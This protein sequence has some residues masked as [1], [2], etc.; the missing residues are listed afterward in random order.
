MCRLHDF[1]ICDTNEDRKII[2]VKESR[3]TGVE[4]KN[5]PSKYGLYLYKCME[6][7]NEWYYASIHK[8]ENGIAV[9]NECD[10]GETQLEDFHYNLTDLFWYKVA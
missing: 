8:D 7:D 1:V 9:V 5:M 2:T 4:S 6:T 3:F 10:L